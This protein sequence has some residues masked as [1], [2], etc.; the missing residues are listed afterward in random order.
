MSNM[1]LLTPGETSKLLQPASDIKVPGL[2]SCYHIHTNCLA[3]KNA[4]RSGNARDCRLHQRLQW[5]VHATPSSL[6]SVIDMH[7][8]HGSAVLKCSLTSP[9]KRSMVM[10]SSSHRACSFIFNTWSKS[11]ARPASWAAS[12]WRT[13]H[14]QD[15]KMPKSHHRGFK[16]ALDYTAC[17]RKRWPAA[18]GEEPQA[19]PGWQAA[20]HRSLL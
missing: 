7:T 15:T 14:T 11:L 1:T 20:A 10:Q 4:R 2:C 18:E 6:I 5:R 13:W 12:L 3:V 9:S 17:R 16:T 19:Y 8:I